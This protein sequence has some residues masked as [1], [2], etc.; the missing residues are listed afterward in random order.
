VVQVEEIDDREQRLAQKSATAY[1][2]TACSI[3][4]QG[5]SSVTCCFHTYAKLPS[6]LKIPKIL[7]GSGAT[8]PVRLPRPLWACD[9]PR[10]MAIEL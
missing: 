8:R 3:C 10:P 7:S 2:S 6:A 5:I 1:A 4:Q 9:A